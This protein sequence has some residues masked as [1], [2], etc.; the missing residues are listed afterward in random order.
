MT[1]D[2]LLSPSEH[3][4]F[5][6][7]AF[8]LCCLFFVNLTNKAVDRYNESVENGQMQKRDYANNQRKISFGLY[9]CLYSTPIYEV[10]LALQFFTNPLLFLLF[11]KRRLGRFVCSFLL[12]FFTFSG[13]IGWLIYTYEA[14]KSDEHFYRLADGFNS[15]LLYN[16]TVLEF[17]LFLIFAILLILQAA[18]LTRFVIE[19]IQARI[20]LR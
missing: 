7:I 5:F 13:Y 6:G 10:V 18:V 11:L 19:K 3:K 12:A 20:Y 17:I 8:L 16:S 4:L 2:K 15:Y 9:D 1:P 14:R